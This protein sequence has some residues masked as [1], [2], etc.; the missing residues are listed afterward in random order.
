VVPVKRFAVAK[1]RLALP[2]A[3]RERVAAAMAADTVAAAT[4]A[5]TVQAVVVVT[6]DPRARDD[7]GALGATVV[8]DRPAAGLND[9]LRFGIETA[10]AAG[11]VAV[12]T[13]SADLPALRATDLDAALASVVDLAVVAD[14][15][16][17]GTTLL[18]AAAVQDLQ[19]A[20]GDGSL[21]RHVAA[22]ARDLSPDVGPR[23]RTDVDV[24]DD[25]LAAARLGLGAATQAVVAA[26]P[27]ILG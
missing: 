24:R 22:G 25:L 14:R 17:T 20:Y 10:R 16:G 15:A 9:A 13:L 26:W 12:A 27:A 21:A 5:A 11:A 3:V 6:D 19:P 18:A 1:S 4:A 2:D 7:L 23:L 8:P